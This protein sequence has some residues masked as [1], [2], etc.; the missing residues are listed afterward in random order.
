[1]NRRNDLTSEDKVIVAC[2]AMIAALTIAALMAI[3][4]TP[5]AITTIVPVMSGSIVAISTLAAR[6]P[7]TPPAAAAPMQ[8]VPTATAAEVAADDATGA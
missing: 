4:I 8:P 3:A 1:M 5:S 7:G 6:H 2:V